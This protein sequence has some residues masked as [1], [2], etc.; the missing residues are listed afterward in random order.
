MKSTKKKLSR[1]I[2]SEAIM[3]TRFH[4]ILVLIILLFIILIIRL[5]WIQ[6]IQTESFTDKLEQLTNRIVEGS[7][8]PRGRIYDRNGKLLVDNKPNKVISYKKN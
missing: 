4:I 8:A 3:G 1:K 7:T 2:Y 5:F 6:V